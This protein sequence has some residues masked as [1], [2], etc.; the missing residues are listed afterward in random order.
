M[1]D[2]FTGEQPKTVSYNL[3]HEMVFMNKK[4]AH[5]ELKRL[6]QL[7]KEGTLKEIMDIMDVMIVNNDHAQEEIKLLI[8]FFDD[9]FGF[10]ELIERGKDLKYEIDLGLHNIPFK[11]FL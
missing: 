10:E 5:M 2:E 8:S 7:N 9:E 1:T 3:V 6:Y 11:G 4:S